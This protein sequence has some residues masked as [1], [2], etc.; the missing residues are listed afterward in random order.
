MYAL[1]GSL[2]ENRKKVKKNAPGQGSGELVDSGIKGS[3]QGDF[4]TKE[5]DQPMEWTLLKSCSRRVC[6]VA[7][8]TVH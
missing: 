1:S 4:S 7:N 2:K 5:L 3:G 6:H 8:L